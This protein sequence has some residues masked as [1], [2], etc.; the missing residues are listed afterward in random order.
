MADP[1]EAEGAQASILVATSIRTKGELEKNKG[2]RGE[3]ENRGGCKKIMKISTP[4]SSC[5][6][7]NL[8]CSHWSVA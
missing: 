5:G 3:Q 7:I 2:R 4:L 1:V 6:W 8:C